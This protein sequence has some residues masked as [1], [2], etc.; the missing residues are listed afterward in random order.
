MPKNSYIIV[1][2]VGVSTI[3]WENAAENAIESAITSLEEVRVAE[4]VKMDLIIEKG[5]VSLYRI[6]VTMSFKYI[7]SWWILK[8]DDY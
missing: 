6:R 1:E 5:V 4:V 3:S 2:L 8:E 7:D